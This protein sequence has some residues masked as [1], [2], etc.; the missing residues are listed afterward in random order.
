[1]RGRG[2][3]RSSVGELGNQF[4]I[5]GLHIVNHDIEFFFHNFFKTLCCFIL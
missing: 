4:L 2:G 5:I 3:G 1:M